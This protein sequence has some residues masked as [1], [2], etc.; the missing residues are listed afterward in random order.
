MLSIPL[1]VFR[2]SAFHPKIG[3]SNSRESE[4]DITASG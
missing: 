4:P 3:L 1:N 2:I